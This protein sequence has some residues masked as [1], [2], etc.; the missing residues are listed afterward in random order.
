MNKT[1][2]IFSLAGRVALV[3]GA[4]GYLGQSISYALAEAGAKVILCGRGELKLRELASRMISDSHQ[5]EV[6]AFD[7]TDFEAITTSINSIKL[8]R[9]DI[10]VNNAYNGSSGS[11]ETSSPE[12]YRDSFGVSVIGA[13]N[14]FQ[15]ALPYLRA[16][17]KIGGYASVINIGSMYGMVAPD[18]QIY[19]G[20]QAANPPYY[21]AAKAALIQWTKYIAAE[22]GGEGIRANAISPG[23]F[24]ST[25]TQLNNPLFVKKLS[26][27]VPLGRIGKS[28]EIKG[29]ITYLASPAASYVTG[30]NLVIDGGWMA[31]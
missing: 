24:P 10:L 2:E 9:L 4:A 20:K 21:G 13:S 3:T 30:S 6:L 19:E 18:H 26:A 16:A 12:Q 14:L 31:L 11:T 1:P 15:V 8:N 29:A 23:P 7:V 27:K 28:D 5:V 17:A 25:E 22:F